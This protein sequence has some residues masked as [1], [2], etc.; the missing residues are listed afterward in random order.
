MPWITCWSKTWCDINGATFANRQLK[1]EADGVGGWH[2][3][4]D[5]KYQI[6]GIL[7][8]WTWSILKILKKQIVLLHATGNRCCWTSRNI[9]FR[10][11]ST[12]IYILC[13]INTR[14]NEPTEWW[15]KPWWTRH[16]YVSKVFLTFRNLSVKAQKYYSETHSIFEIKLSFLN[17]IEIAW[18]YLAMSMISVATAML[19]KEQGITIT[20]I[21]AVYEIF[22]IQKVRHTEKCQQFNRILKP[23]STVVN[24]NNTRK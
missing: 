20:A 21:C 24:V 12:G 23:A 3:Q 10:I 15:V 9:I 5:F 7:N 19:C 2:S 8:D 4:R 16:L 6:V 14:K 22:I 1:R 18:K 17:N 13:K 11:F